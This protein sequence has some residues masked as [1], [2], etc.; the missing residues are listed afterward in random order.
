MTILFRTK[1]QRDIQKLCEQAQ[2]IGFAGYKVIKTKDLIF[3]QRALLQCMNC[4][5]YGVKHTCPPFD[6]H[7]DYE[8]IF[9]SFKY[10][11]FCWVRYEFN[12][13]EEFDAVRTKS[14][15]D[16]HLK[17]LKLERQAFDMG[18]HYAMA[19]IGGSCKL[20]KECA[21][22]QC[23][24]PAKSRVPM[25]STGID[26]CKTMKKY[27]LDLKFPVEH[28]LYRIGLLLVE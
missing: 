11:M 8:K 23:R 15:N 14:T 26:V 2:I 3:D 17:I 18:H 28:E 6:T 9:K 25:E 12:N 7:L 4:K 22:G 19:F 13:K 5:N 1:L 10:G 24:N 27:G 16:L 21:Q 20:C